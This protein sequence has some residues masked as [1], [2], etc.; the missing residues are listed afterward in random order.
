MIRY[1]ELSLERGIHIT[2]PNHADRLPNAKSDSRSDTTVKSFQSILL[3][4]VFCCRA[5][6]EVLRTV[7]I[8]FLALHLNTDDL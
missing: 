2:H 6:R 1:K 4:N 3:V 7:R 5:D 8:L